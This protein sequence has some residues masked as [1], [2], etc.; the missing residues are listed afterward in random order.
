MINMNNGDSIHNINTLQW[1]PSSAVSHLENHVHDHRQ[2]HYGHHHQ[3]HHHHEVQLYRQ[4][5]TNG[6]NRNSNINTN[7]NKTSNGNENGNILN[8]DKTSREDRM[9]GMMTRLRQHRLIAGNSNSVRNRNGNGN[10]NDNDN[11]NRDSS[12]N[13]IGNSIGNSNGSS[14]GK[15]NRGENNL[16]VDLDIMKKKAG[17]IELSATIAPA[18]E[19]TGA[20]T[21]R[22][23][24][25]NMGRYQDG[26][27][28]EGQRTEIQDGTL[29][30]L[31]PGH[32]AAHGSGSD[33]E[34]H[35]HGTHGEKQHGEEH[36]QEQGHH[37][38]NRQRH[39]RG[40]GHGRGHG[41]EGMFRRQHGTA[42]GYGF[43]EQH[44]M[45]PGT[46][47]MVDVQMMEIKERMQSRKLRNLE[48][49]AMN[50]Q[51]AQHAH[52]ISGLVNQ[53]SSTT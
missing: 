35:G 34:R 36:A 22:Q 40:Q 10:G 48:L 42:A 2:Q 8:A 11:D 50:Q 20:E 27:L 15:G 23:R 37:R 17:N 51:V 19:V 9:Q 24:V 41:H 43:M 38:A 5:G 3:Q 14:N 18:A 29:V 52:L 12:G 1:R 31:G 33:T 45:R 26:Q 21:R 6:S 32:A 30:R 28:D 47:T 39:G 46:Y 25:S 44:G 49:M 53:C 13:S 7:T 16:D 4:Y